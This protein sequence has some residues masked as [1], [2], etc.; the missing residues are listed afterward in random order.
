M[1]NF[2]KK[3]LRFSWIRSSR[4]ITTNGVSH[5]PALHWTAEAHQTIARQIGPHIKPKIRLKYHIIRLCEVHGN[6]WWPLIN[7]RQNQHQLSDTSANLLRIILYSNWIRIQSYWN[8]NIHTIF[9]NFQQFSNKN[10]RCRDY[11]NNFITTYVICKTSQANW[12][13]GPFEVYCL[14]TTFFKTFM[15]LLFGLSLS[16][17]NMCTK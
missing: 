6:D 13:I 14:F 8:W 9:Y 10:P 5:L 12:Q 1:P 7:R 4:R 3:L 17:S 2:A 11:S 15:S 16:I